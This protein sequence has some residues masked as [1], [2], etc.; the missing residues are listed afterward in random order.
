MAPLRT[1]ED[2]ANRFKTQAQAV[3]ALKSATAKIEKAFKD[4][5]SVTL[6]IDELS[7]FI[8]TSMAMHAD[9]TNRNGTFYE[10]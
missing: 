4:E 1:A 6:T 5:A 7:A 10:E 8:Y 3:A 9:A 2:L